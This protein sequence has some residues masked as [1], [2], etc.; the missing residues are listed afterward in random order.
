MFAHLNA[1]LQ[2]ITTIRAYGA[3][4]TLKKEFDNH[5]VSWLSHLCYVLEKYGC[6]F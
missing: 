2:G 5:Q 6:Y 3:E 4:A 1:T